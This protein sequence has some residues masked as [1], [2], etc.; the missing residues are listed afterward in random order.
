MGFT[1][2]V[3]VLLSASVLLGSARDRALRVSALGVPVVAG[4]VYLVA[5]LHERKPPAQGDTQ[6]GLVALVGIVVTTACLAA[7]LAGWA[8]HAARERRER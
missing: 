5:W 1:A 6:P 3:P 8:R 4:I 7:V 2:L